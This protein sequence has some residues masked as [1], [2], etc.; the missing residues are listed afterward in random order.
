MMQKYFLVVKMTNSVCVNR[1]LF[2]MK[3]TTKY[4]K[5]SNF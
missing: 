3:S 4:G 1:K 5:Q 2:R